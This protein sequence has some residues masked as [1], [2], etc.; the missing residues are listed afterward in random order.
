VPDVESLSHAAKGRSCR[1]SG[2]GKN[3]KLG[4]THGRPPLLPPEATNRFLTPLMPS[5]TF[6]AF[7]DF[8]GRLFRESAGEDEVDF[9]IN[10][11]PYRSGR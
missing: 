11:L 4:L 6:D 8:T 5:D 10:D 1:S 2:E 3:W 7:V 9:R